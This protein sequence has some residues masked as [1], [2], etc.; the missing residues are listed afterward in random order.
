MDCTRRRRFLPAAV[1]AGCCLALLAGCNTRTNVGVA[2]TAPVDAAHLWVTVEEVWFATEASTPPESD[3]GWVRETLSNPVVLDLASIDPAGLVALATNVSVPAG[4]YRQLY[5]KLA[6]AGDRL[7]DAAREAGLVYNAQIDVK[8][9]SGNVSKAP[10]EMPVPRM[11][12]AIPMELTFSDSSRLGNDS[13]EALSLAVTLDA[14]RDVVTYDYGSNTG[15]ILSPSVAVHDVAKSGAIAGSVDTS[16][17]PSGHAPVYVSAQA[18]DETGSHHV[19]VQRRR[20]S[21]GGAFSLYP[22]PGAKSGAKLYDVVI[23]CSGADTVIVRDVPVT[24]G[25]AAAAL[26]PAA[27][28][29]TQ[30]RTV[31]AN[32]GTQVPALPA[33]SRA[34]F[35]Q[36][37]PGSGERPYLV[38]GTAIEPLTGQLPGA[39]LPLAAGSLIVG[40]YSDGGPIAFSVVTP[41]EGT[42]SYVVGSAGPYRADTLAARSTDVS[43]GINRPTVVEVPYPELVAGGRLGSLTVSILASPGRH[44]SGFITVMA[45]SWL[46]E[47]VDIGTLLERGGGLVTIDGLPAGSALAA[48]AGVPFR[49]AVRAWNSRNASGTLTWSA[50]T[51]SVILG[52]TGVGSVT[53][54]VQ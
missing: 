44:D 46:I 8:I 43:G 36:S 24:A 27:V 18:T 21:S 12:L 19:V 3:T 4:D 52:D 34:E 48:P 39:A 45:G 20:I 23:T 49:V 41:A 2:G 50:S 15:Y 11:G 37:L 16:G 30:A 31:Y 32:A 22:L 38:D 51:A 6:D 17:L 5:L 35:Y 25:S 14:A 26:Q 9:G 28:V 47:T 53:L 29:L 10:L 1:L 40:S 7:V 13:D 42:G 54:Q 33:G